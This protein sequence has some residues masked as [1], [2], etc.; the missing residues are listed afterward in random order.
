MY[1]GG[2]RTGVGV[3]VPAGV[4]E[5]GLRI[6]VRVSWLST[7]Q[8]MS[9]WAGVHGCGG[10][11]SVTCESPAIRIRSGS[12]ARRNVCGYQRVYQGPAGGPAWDAKRRYGL[13]GF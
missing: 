12:P 3:T 2:V 6:S 7:W 11:V 1:V 8:P 10:R 9:F 5:D 4:G 13:H